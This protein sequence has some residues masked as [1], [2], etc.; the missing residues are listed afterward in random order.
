MDI[1]PHE[2]LWGIANQ[3]HDSGT[4]RSAA[5]F[6][7]GVRLRGEGVL[8]KAGEYAIPSGSSMQDIVD[9]LVSGRVVEHKFTAAEGLTSQMITGLVNADR[10]LAGPPQQ[11]PEEGSLLPETYLFA[12]GTA[13][14]AILARM[15][16]AQLRFLAQ[17]WPSRDP[18]FPLHSPREAVTLA[19]IVEKETAIP[20]ERRHI[21]AVFINR[22][23]LGMKLESDPTVIYGLS[24]GYP[25]GHGI[26]ASELASVTP[27]NTYLI[28]GLPPTP[29]CNPGKDSISAVLNPDHSG[30]LYFVADGTGGHVFAAT[31]AEQ[32]RNV[33][34]WRQIE[35]TA[36]RLKP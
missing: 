9:L 18:V 8:L 33:A 1:R 21:A 7:V 22:L 11:A 30:D 12:K 2:G 28:S 14:G 25:L 16:E 4:V 10:E 27:Y 32:D 19:S 3:L 13:R 24:K 36:L 31:K 17:A 35:N 15:H 26:R 34:R 20:E 29:I 5:L 6:A 23:R